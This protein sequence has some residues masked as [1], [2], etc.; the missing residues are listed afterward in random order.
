MFVMRAIEAAD[1]P[2]LVTLVRQV[3]S[4][5]TTLKP[6]EPAL[7]KRLQI[8]CASFEG[9]L[10]AAQADYVF[11]MED[12]GSAQVVGISAI[13]AAVGLTEP[14]Y[15][16]RVGRLVHSSTDLGV[17]ACKEMLY[18]S[19]DLT[20]CAE[21]CS[22]YLGPSFRTGTNGKLLSKARFL[23]MAQFVDLFP[24]VVIAEMRGFQRHDGTSPFWDSLGRHFF[25]MEFARADDLMSL[26]KKSFIAELMPKYPVYVDYLTDEA[27][28]VLGEVHV[29]TVPAKRLLEEEGMHYEGYIDIFDAGPV[30]QGRSQQLRAIRESQLAIAQAGDDEHVDDSRFLVSNTRRDGFRAIVASGQLKSGNFHLSDAELEALRI[31]AGDTIRLM[32]L[33]AGT[34]S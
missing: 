25:K 19:C 23:F 21:L 15:N 5:M 18:L 33:T 22:L 32:T 4:G 9:R 13:K 3:G 28:A 11:I 8:A 30:L 31:Q 10:A 17:Y 24:D 1:L 20:G 14:F 26:G 6:D 27:K 29:D 16:F 34:R 2:G 7:Q 12:T